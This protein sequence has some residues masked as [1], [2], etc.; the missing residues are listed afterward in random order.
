MRILCST[1]NATGYVRQSPAAR[2]IGG[3]GAT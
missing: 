1:L 2:Q 3:Q